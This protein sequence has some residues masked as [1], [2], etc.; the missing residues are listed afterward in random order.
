MAKH[1]AGLSRRRFLAGAAGAGGLGVLVACGNQVGLMQDAPYATNTARNLGNAPAPAGN[2]ARGSAATP[3]ASGSAMTGMDPATTGQN[4]AAP[5]ATATPAKDWQA[6]SQMHAAG[7]KTFLAQPK[8]LRGGQRMEYTMQDGVKVFNLTAKPMQWEVTPGQM[9]EAYAYNGV[10]PGPQIRVT[11][12]DKV[13]VILKNELDEATAIHYHGLVIPNAMDGVP[14]ITQPPVNPGESFTY[15]FTAKNPGSHM[16]H[17]HMNSALQVTKGLLGAFIIKPKDRSAY[18]AFDQE[19]T[20][21][22]NDGPLGFTLNGKGFPGTEA[23][24]VKQG[25]RLLIRYM[26]EGLMIHPMHLHGMPMTIIGQDGYLNT[27]YKCDTV[28][29]APGQRIEAIVECTEV[30]AWAWHCHI[31]SHAEG[32][33]G[34]FGMVTALIVT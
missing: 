31:L 19:Y 22:L 33:M 17:S 27:P 18:P 34:M 21:I 16:Y 30:G 26:N 14:F 5:A 4:A 10:V 23:V 13:R 11:E 6:M 25:T 1:Y 3:A 28:N 9:V 32:E 20:M 24:T 8:T 15:E 12:G 7:V 29:I 2:A